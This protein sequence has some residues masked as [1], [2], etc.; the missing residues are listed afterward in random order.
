MYAV[1]ATFSAFS[2]TKKEDTQ[3][4]LQS[5]A[6]DKKWRNKIEQTDV[7]TTVLTSNR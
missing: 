3:K 2:P 4:D 1:P 5:S 6:K 7:D